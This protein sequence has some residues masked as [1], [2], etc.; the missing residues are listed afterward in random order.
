MFEA[1]FGVRSEG[2]VSVSEIRSERPVDSV[3]ETR[4]VRESNKGSSAIFYDFTGIK[5]CLRVC[6]EIFEYI[7][8]KKEKFK[9]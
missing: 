4:F 9:T 2:M 5:I 6:K 3:V 8:Y 7:M 1:V